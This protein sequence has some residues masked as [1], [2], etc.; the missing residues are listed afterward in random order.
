MIVH[1]DTP[2]M[3]IEMQVPSLDDAIM[4]IG[5]AKLIMKQAGNI[6]V[7]SRHKPRVALAR[8]QTAPCTIMAS[9]YQ[10]L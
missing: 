8:A 3:D 7:L 10:S 9:T 2:L 4:F 5:L 6:Q 1:S